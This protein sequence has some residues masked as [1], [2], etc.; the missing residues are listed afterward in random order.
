LKQK[1]FEL[2]MD[3]RVA[4]TALR[5]NAMVP[6]PEEAPWR[7]FDYRDRTILLVADA[8]VRPFSCKR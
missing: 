8:A 4:L 1:H 3:D 7:R 6:S 2:E 5:R